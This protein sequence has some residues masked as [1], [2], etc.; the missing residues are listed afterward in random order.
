MASSS[1]FGNIVNDNQV[2]SPEENGD[3][4][5]TKTNKLIA[6]HCQTSVALI[7]PNNDIQ[8]PTK[9][10]LLLIRQQSTNIS[11]SLPAFEPTSTYGSFN[12]V[13]SVSNIAPPPN[14]GFTAINSANNA[15]IAYPIAG[16]PNNAS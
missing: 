6:Q 10:D 12:T 16:T 11:G 3:P 2:N 5:E 9:L 13:P 1:S 8:R 14:V 4:R 7:P 15:T